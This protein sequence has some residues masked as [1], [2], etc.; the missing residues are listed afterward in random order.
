MLNYEQL[1]IN[2]QILDSNIK[3]DIIR[4]SSYK[5]RVTE[6]GHHKTTRLLGKL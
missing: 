2:I 5:L 3:L 1:L 6:T 4:G